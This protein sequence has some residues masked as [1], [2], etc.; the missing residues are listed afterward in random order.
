MC[1]SYPAV[2]HAMIAISVWHTQLERIPSHKED[3][4]PRLALHHSTKAIACLRE[5]LAQE[6]LAPHS[7]NR[8]HKQVVLVT[9]LIFTALALFQGDF[10][11]ARYHLISGYR[12]FKEWD[13]Q[14]DKGATGQALRQAFVQMHV[15]WFFC[16]HSELFVQD[17]ELL[18]GEYQI[19]PNTT[20][21]LPKI[22]PHLYS[23]IDHMECV[24]E[25][26][27]LISDL[28]LDRTTCG[29]NIGPASSTGYNAT[30]VL[31]KLRLCKSRLMAVLI[32]LDSLAAEDCETLK[33][34]SLCIDIIGLKLAVAKSSKPDEMAY[35]DHLE[36]FRH[37]TKLAQS[38]AGSGLGSSDTESSPFN[39]RDAI[40]PALLWSAAKCRDWQVRR[41]LCSIMHKRPGDDYWIS[42][43]TVALK[44]L[45]DVESIGV[46]SGNIIPEAARAYLVNVEIQHKESKVELR[47]C[48]PR[49]VPH[50]RHGG[51]E[52]ESDSMNY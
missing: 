37:I 34:F 1:E 3:R 2:R 24:Q 46:K 41:D 10:C 31:I 9:C 47:Y 21:A 8:T 52:W 20:A 48:R 50:S 23:A 51:D 33:F 4:Y 43:T 12:L 16:S 5:S 15:H 11:S 49:Y 27:T 18:Y 45:I 29:F 30:V 39:H 28:I 38:L 14:K 40:F 13:V 22:T 19:S 25:F 26:A 35:D 6:S 17:A 7:L 36:Q 44:R 32:E 42:A